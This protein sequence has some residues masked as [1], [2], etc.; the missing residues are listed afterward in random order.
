MR[1]LVKD[2]LIE[3]AEML[4][5]IPQKGEN[6]AEALPVHAPNFPHDLEPVIRADPSYQVPSQCTDDRHESVAVPS[7][8]QAVWRDLAPAVLNAPFPVTIDEGTVKAPASDG[9]H[10]RR[11]GPGEPLQRLRREAG[12][13]A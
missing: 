3:I 13:T 1:H 6:S 9:Q 7:K 4:P 12:L 5:A 11:R 2:I 10:A 8:L